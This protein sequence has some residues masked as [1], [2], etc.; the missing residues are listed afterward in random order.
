MQYMSVMKGVLFTPK[1]FFTTF[2][3]EA[4][5]Q[6]IGQS[7]VFILVMSLIGGAIAAG[8][9]L[10]FPAPIGNRWVALGA[11]IFYPIAGV[12]GSFLSAGVVWLIV[13]ALG[14]KPTYQ[15]VF[16][17]MAALAAFMPLSALFS[18]VIPVSV[19]I[20]LWSFVAFVLG[21]IEILEVKPVKA[22][23]TFG[24]LAVILTSLS[25]WAMRT[26]QQL[27]LQSQQQNAEALPLPGEAPPAES[28]AP[29]AAQ[30][31]QPAPS[32]TNK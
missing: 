16:A 3:N 18:R 27:L 15:T 6:P 7:A 21:V 32:S 30:P 2:K 8:L 25:F 26:S 4:N 19:I 31:E 23:A 5:Q 10:A 22:W 14:V 28:A 17:L 11:V 12:L 1:T 20:S 24:I 29:A 9:G 13:R